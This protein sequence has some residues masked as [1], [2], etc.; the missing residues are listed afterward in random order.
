MV[1]SGLDKT[2][3]VHFALLG[4]IPAEMKRL[5]QVNDRGI[6][7]ERA[8]TYIDPWEPVDHALITHAHSDHARWGNK[9]YLCHPDT[10]LILKIR[11]GDNIQ[12]QT[13]AFGEKIQINGVTF[14]FH[15]AGHILGS[16][17]IRVAYKDE[18]WV[19]S[20]DYK[21]LNDGLSQPYEPVICHHFITE[22]TFGLPIYQFETPFSNYDA[23]KR[24]WA[25]NQSDQVNTVLLCYA[26]GKAQSI[27]N[28]LRDDPE[29]PIFLHGAVANVNEAF[30]ANGYYFPGER[31]DAGKTVDAKQGALILAPPAALGTPWMRRF[32]AYRVAMC[33]GW[34][35]LRGARRRRGVDKGFVL[36]DHC[37][38]EQLNEAIALTKAENIYVTHGYESQ[39]TRWLQE[40]KGLQAQVMNT[41]YH[42]LEIDEI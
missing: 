16:A 12:I 18:I 20:G 11:L 41:L 40:E 37:D 17:Q 9:K 21:L 15:P 34:M 3:R 28:Q 26:L 25:E 24:W 22:S 13:L 35:Q 30:A 10:A 7:C 23:I 1:I 36:S 6:Y 39:F 8:K 2:N 42:D 4:Y 14:S 29:G 38:F 19:V 5:L 31:M 27:L 33:S 32:G